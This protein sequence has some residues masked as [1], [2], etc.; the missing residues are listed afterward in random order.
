ME[1]ILTYH[2]R[3]DK[4]YGIYMRCLFFIIAVIVGCSTWVMIVNDYIIPYYN[5]IL[6]FGSGF[7]IGFYMPRS[8]VLYSE[9]AC[10]TFTTNLIRDGFKI[11]DIKPLYL[12]LH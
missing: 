2:V 7:M 9:D 5:H 11:L 6:F 12:P 4:E 3:Y 8:K 10:F 1:E